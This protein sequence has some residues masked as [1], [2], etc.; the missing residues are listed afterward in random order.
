MDI[1]WLKMD[2]YLKI[3]IQ[4]LLIVKIPLGNDSYFPLIETVTVLVL[5]YH[6]QIFDINVSLWIV[7]YLSVSGTNNAF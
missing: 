3:R 4:I 5:L 1:V 6:T 2:E 7:S